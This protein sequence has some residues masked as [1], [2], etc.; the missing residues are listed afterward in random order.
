[1]AIIDNR[2][3]N[4]NLPLPNASNALR[5][6][7]ERIRQTFTTLDA[8]VSA[9]Q[10]SLGYTPENV[11]NKG[12]ANGYA[13]L[14][15][16]TKIPAAQLPA[17]TSG[18]VLLKGD[19]AGGFANASAGTDYV[20]PSGSI[21]GSANS[22][23]SP[24]TTGLAT[25][26]GPAAGTTRNYTVP[27]ADATI[28]TD[29]ALVSVAQGGTG[30]SSAAGALDNLLPSGEVSGYVL[31]TSGPGTYYWAAGGGGGG[32][33]ASGT[34]ITTSRSTFTAT[35]GQTLFSGLGSYV[36]GAGQVRVYINGVRLFPSD[37]TE[38]STTSI[39]LAVGA[40]AGDEVMV[41]IDGYSTFELTATNTTFS[42]TGGIASTNVQSALAELDAEKAKAGSNNDITSLSGL[43]TALSVAQG[44]TGRTTLASGG[45]VIG[46]GTNGLNTLT[47]SSIG[48]IAQWNGSAWTAA[49][50]PASG[51]TSVTAS[52][53]LASSGGTTPN[54]SFTGTL[55][56]ANG[57][58]GT[59][60]ATGSGSVVLSTTPSITG[61]REVRVAGGTGGSY[62]VNLATGNYFTRTFNSAATI[63]VSNVPTSGTAQAFIFDINNA[64]AY[65]ITWMT[66][67]KW[68]S[69]VAPTLT[70]SGR[71]VLGFFTHDGGATW[72]GLLLAK[73]IK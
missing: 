32:G 27:N 40:V 1:M 49:S 18:N 7:V 39:T 45:L 15:A 22:V 54:I 8:E 29:A 28:L 13:S 62:A 64:G 51:V 52:A 6:D 72:N 68:A 3:T 19:G 53:P 16:T 24:V 42:P 5:D 55:A 44:G 63:S 14:D 17:L 70:A 48:Q 4:L 46:A 73:D 67:I 9:K 36:I 34:T 65:T 43:T 11:A 38:T 10:V 59:T 47:G 12:A 41:E 61:E 56:V 26:T 69:G 25:F 66:G 21:T 2:T 23:K 30:S 20:V 31:T 37:Y 71:D 60:T 50:L 33:G 57:G 58:T 35:S